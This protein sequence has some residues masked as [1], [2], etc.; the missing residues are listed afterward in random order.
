MEKTD[1]QKNIKNKYLL[2]DSIHNE[3]AFLLEKE[4]N[5][6]NSEENPPNKVNNENILINY[7]KNKNI[8]FNDEVYLINFIVQLNNYLKGNENI[9]FPFLDLVPDL[10]KAY[11]QSSIDEEKIGEYKYINIFSSL[12]KTTFISKEN[13]FPIY[14]FFSK[15]FSD[16]ATIKEDDI[17]LKKLMKIVDLLLI[18]FLLI[19]M[20]QKTNIKNQVYAFWGG[21]LACFSEKK[22]LWKIKILKLKLIF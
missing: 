6:I 20:I 7:F 12:I 5:N 15:F 1:I 17:R 19:K 22:F 11:I 16:V 3:I 13:L 9:I 21:V 8:I 10:V 14:S 2:L 4:K 18:F